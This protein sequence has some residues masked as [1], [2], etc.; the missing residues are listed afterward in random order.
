[1]KENRGSFGGDG[2]V[3]YLVFLVV[4]MYVLSNTLTAT[5]SKG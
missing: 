3:L 4:Q 1:M 2:T 5:H